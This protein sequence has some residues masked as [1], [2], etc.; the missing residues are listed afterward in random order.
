MG[1][2]AMRIA[3]LFLLLLPLR[4]DEFPQTTISNGHVEATL[5][6]PDAQKGYYRGTRFDWS[7]VIASLHAAGHDYFG[8]WFPAYDPKLHD[9]I[10]GPVEEFLTG[11][12]AL[13]Y[14]AAKPGGTFV[15]IG[16]G[17]LRKPDEKEFHRFG[18]YEIVDPGR[19]QVKTHPGSVEFTHTLADPATGYGYVYKKTIRLPDGKAAMRIEHSLR[20]TGRQPIATSVYNH[21]F[22]RLDGQP[23]G[24]GFRVRFPFD[25]KA[26][27]DWKGIAETSGRDIVYR[28]PVPEKQSIFGILTGYG[29]SPSDYDIRVENQ[30]A[31]VRFRGDRPI[32]KIVYWSIPTTLCPEVYIDLMIPPG[33]ETHWSID[34]DFYSLR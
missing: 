31:G 28:Q 12:S 24:P 34:Y 29:P 23:T 32:S 15:R 20:N 13:G 14:D 11:D 1:P 25:V 3:T 8:V 30:T 33:Q 27:A 18:Y 6:L 17:V 26:D 22:F 7:G 21:N 4:A 2:L 10:T 16:I 5:Y 9:A 19:W